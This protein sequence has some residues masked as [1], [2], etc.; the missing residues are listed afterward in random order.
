TTGIVTEVG[1]NSYYVQDTHGDGNDATSDAV[2]VFTGGAPTVAVG[3]A[4]E[5]RGK[6]A[7][8][9]SDPGVGLTTT[10]IDAPTTTIV[11]HGNALPDAVLIGVD[12]RLPPNMVIDDD[13]LTSYDPVHDGIDF[14]ESLEG[15]R[16]TVE[17]PLVIQS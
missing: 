17:N 7:E 14:Y 5:V 2:L 10:E 4:V 13:G 15:M 12:G 11:S 16:V 6:V 8:F 1:P 3:D 9:S